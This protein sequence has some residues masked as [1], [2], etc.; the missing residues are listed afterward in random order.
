MPMEQILLLLHLAGAAGLGALLLFAIA[1]LMGTRT[2]RQGTSLADGQ[3]ARY[4]WYAKSIGMGT[5]VQLVTGS[6]LSLAGEDG[7]LLRFCARIGAYLVIIGI[8]EGALFLRIHRTVAIL[9]LRFVGSSLA[10]G[11][12]FV[13]WA[14]GD[15][16]L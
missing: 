9:P 2:A 10:I 5:G 14:V 13:L 3:N 11:I 7:S 16:F 12:V 15:L 6:L 1:T 4:V 8:V